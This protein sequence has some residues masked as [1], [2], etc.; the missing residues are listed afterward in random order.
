[1][2]YIKN[3]LSI[4]LLAAI[5]LTVF[6]VSFKIGET[7]F[8]VYK[9]TVKDSLQKNITQNSKKMPDVAVVPKAD[10]QVDRE[11]KSGV[12]ESAPVKIVE[13]ASG[14]VEKVSNP[15]MEKNMVQPVQ[16]VVAPV[17][18]EKTEVKPSVERKLPQSA[19]E[20]VP[21]S[22]STPIP[23]VTATETQSTLILAAVANI[24]S[25]PNIKS[26]I[27][28]KLKKGDSVVILSITGDWLNVKLSS[29][30]TG[31]V[32]KIL[33]NMVQPVQKV[34][35]PVAKTERPADASKPEI[36]APVV[37]PEAIAS[38]F[39]PATKAPKPAAEKNAATAKAPR[40]HKEYKVIAGSFSIKANAD[41]LVSQLKENNYEPMVVLAETPKGQ[42]YRVIVGSY[43]SLS[44]TKIKISELKELGF[45]PFYIVE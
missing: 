7:I 12:K 32:F 29:G 2:K 5:V 25:E 21:P 9:T 38:K 20:E 28:S 42:L 33:T 11:V 44:V 43:R 19:K 34:V 45:Q 24:R 36:S 8:F 40:T 39:K 23:K 3:V 6:G 37:K 27:I 14:Q 15:V 22:S 1:M 13:S 18:K 17:A 41:S 31:W 10:E 16:K 35:A 4:L 26:K 30:L